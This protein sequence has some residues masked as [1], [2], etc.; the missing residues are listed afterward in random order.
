MK[1]PALFA[2]AKT[3]AKLLNAKL[4]LV[5]TRVSKLD[6]D[7]RGKGNFSWDCP[8]ALCSRRPAGGAGSLMVPPRASLLV[9]Y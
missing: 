9:G 8:I 3:E 1:K 4:F 2:E 6:E 7:K 5:V